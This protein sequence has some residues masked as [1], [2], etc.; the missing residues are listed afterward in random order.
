MTEEFLMRDFIEGVRIEFIDENSLPDPKTVG[1]VFLIG[2]I[3]DKIIAA[4]NERGWDLPGG[5]VEAKDAN[6]VE[7]LKREV[8]EEAGAIVGDVKP[9]AI[10]RVKGKEKAMLFYASKNC[11]LV[12][13]IPKEDA[14][15]R[16]LMTIPE[17]IEKYHWKKDI[18][19]MLIKRALD[20]LRKS[21]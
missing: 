3:G 14:F 1:A 15:E 18:M 12:E 16:E 19:E 5:H 13:F 20:V 8:D 17:F 4:R 11:R 6:L 9:Y 21:K 10:M 2:F 7:A